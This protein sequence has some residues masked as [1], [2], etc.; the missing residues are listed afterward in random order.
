[1]SQFDDHLKSKYK[2]KSDAAAENIKNISAKTSASSNNYYIGKRYNK[3]INKYINTKRRLSI[4]SQTSNNS[5]KQTDSYRQ[6]KSNFNKSYN[7][8]A[9]IS[10]K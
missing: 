5:N 8:S 7:N 1:M 3:N 4:A 2:D 6:I 10:I 9:N